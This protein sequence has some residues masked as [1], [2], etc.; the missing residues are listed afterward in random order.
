M[1]KR[2]IWKKGV[3][4][5]Q[6]HIRKTTI[7]EVG[8]GSEVWAVAFSVMWIW[9]SWEWLPLMFCICTALDVDEPKIYVA[10]FQQ[11]YLGIRVEMSKTLRG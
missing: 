5:K 3:V 2:F 4:M 10:A 6:H 8:R 7:M 9:V 11:R 1:G